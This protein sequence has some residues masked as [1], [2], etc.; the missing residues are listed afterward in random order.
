[1]IFVVNGTFT[2]VGLEDEDVEVRGYVQIVRAKKN[3]DIAGQ[4][5]NDVLLVDL[6]VEFMQ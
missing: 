2:R 1:M 6:I 3:C 4:T 5:I